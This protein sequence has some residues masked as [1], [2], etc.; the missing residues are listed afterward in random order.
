[1]HHN[2]LD[3]AKVKVKARNLHHIDVKFNAPVFSHQ[4]NTTFLLCPV[5]MTSPPVGDI[6][7]TQVDSIEPERTCV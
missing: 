1:M 2:E 3:V 4:W 6:Y 5:I 7:H